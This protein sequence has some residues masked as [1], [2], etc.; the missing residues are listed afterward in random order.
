MPALR[1]EEWSALVEEFPAPIANLI[2]VSKPAYQGLM[3]HP[4]PALRLVGVELEV[5]NLTLNSARQICK[6]LSARN[7]KVQEDGSIPRVTHCPCVGA[8]E[9]VCGSEIPCSC[10]CT[11]FAGVEQVYP[12]RYWVGNVSYFC[13]LAFHTQGTTFFIPQFTWVFPGNSPVEHLVADELMG[14][15]SPELLEPETCGFCTS[16]GEC[17]EQYYCEQ[18]TCHCLQGDCDCPFVHGSEIV[19]PPF[20]TQKGFEKLEEICV[21]V[22]RAGGR[23]QNGDNS[24]PSHCTGLHVHIDARDLTVS[25]AVAIQKEFHTNAV[26]GFHEAHPSII[27]EWRLE[28]KWCKLEPHTE[29]DRYKACNLLSLTRHGTIEFRIGYLGTLAEVDSEGTPEEAAK[30]IRSYVEDLRTWFEGTLAVLRETAHSAGS[31]R[32][33]IRDK[34]RMEVLVDTVQTF[35]VFKAEWDSWAGRWRVWEA[36]RQ[37]KYEKV[38]SLKICKPHPESLIVDEIIER[39]QV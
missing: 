20:K 7:W 27:P 22:F 18:R 14:F 33:Q 26:W 19:S 12:R 38:Y 34:F 25:E 37:A 32:N 15:E 2:H 4:A 31:F 28:K 6:E 8:D 10:V 21:E 17:Q 1:Y 23:A 13:R 39:S 24:D 11:C 9:C 29:E 30:A 35:G 16:G 5:S 3:P 36:N